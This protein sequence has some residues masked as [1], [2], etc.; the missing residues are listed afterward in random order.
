MYGES[1]RAAVRLALWML[2]AWWAQ[3][4]TAEA[5]WSDAEKEDFLR[6]AEITQIQDLEIG[7]T[8]S[9]R[10]TLSLYGRSH[11]AHVQ[12]VDVVK[13][14]PRVEGRP[15]R[16]F[17]DSYRYNIAAYRLDRL[18]GLHMVPVSIERVVGGRKAAVTWWVDAVMMMERDR[19]Q[20]GIPPAHP[21]PWFLQ[22]SRLRVFNELVYNADFNLG[23]MLITRDWK[24]WLIDFTRA[25]R[26][27]RKLYF[28]GHLWKIEVTL[29]QR[30]RE[31]TL[32]ELESRLG[33]YLIRREIKALLARRDAIVE[34]FEEAEA[35]EG[36]GAVI[37]PDGDPF[38][39][40]PPPPRPLY[41]SPTPNDHLG[42][43]ALGVR[44]QLAEG[45]RQACQE[46]FRGGG[47]PAFLASTACFR[48][49]IHSSRPSRRR[50]KLPGI[51][52]S[53]STRSARW[54]VAPRSQFCTENVAQAPSRGF[55]IP[56]DS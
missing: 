18:L 37:V 26:P 36:A 28:P 47:H 56:W 35:R 2:V 30:L 9:R 29:L 7:A 1:R 49:C 42:L 25:F 21:K 45:L 11:D 40:P 54:Q 16:S 10:A 17:R 39:A 33:G 53:G 27:S 3:S 50:G 19:V 52:R 24:V 38:P 13:H 44:P 48:S 20:R 15:G 12:T 22:S 6:R 4:L 46:L 43:V 32:E 41:P 51:G 34:Y 31:L 5:P 14:E 8:R 23:N 55:A